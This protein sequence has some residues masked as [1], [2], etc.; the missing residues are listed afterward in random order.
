MVLSG[1]LA[2]ARA[3]RQAHARGDGS[4]HRVQRLHRRMPFA[5]E[6]D[7]AQIRVAVAL[8]GRQRRPAAVAPVRPYP[9][10]QP[11]RQR[12]RATFELGAWPARCKPAERAIARHQPASAAAA[13]RGEPFDRWFRDVGNR[14][15]GTGTEN[16]EPRFCRPLSPIPYGRPLPRHLHHLQRP[17]DRPGGGAR[18]GGGRLRGAAAAPADLL[19][20]ADDLERAAGRG[21]GAGDAAAGVAGALR[22]GWHA[23]RRAGAEL[24]PDLPRRIPRPARRPARRRACASNRS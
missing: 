8:P 13:F 24:H 5:R 20:A 11:D 17:G 15:Q 18:A 16:G 22:P 1:A 7:P 2:P 21:E 10:D 14:E 9:P 12:A 19:R 3:D 6:H 4:V 23:D